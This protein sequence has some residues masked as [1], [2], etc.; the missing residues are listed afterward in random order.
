MKFGGSSLANAERVD[1]V[2]SLIKSQ[3]EQGYRPTVVCSAMGKTTNNLLNA[4]HFA[5]EGS[6]YIDS[7]RTLHLSTAQELGMGDEV[8]AALEELLDELKNLLNGVS[9]L[10]E[11]TPRTLDYLVSFGERLS[12]RIVAARLNQLGVP[13]QHFESWSL[14]LRTNSD[15]GK[16]EI[17]PESY[18][19]I[20]EAMKKLDDSMVAVVTGFIGH[21]SEGRITTLGRGG[22][23]LTASTI[24]A[25]VPVDEIQVWKD[26]NGIMT[27]NPKVVSN[28][29][30]VPFVSFEEASELAYFGAEILHPISMVPAM[31]YNIQVRVK[32][33]YNPDHPGTVILADK[34]YTQLVT[35]ITSKRNV[36]LLDIV[37]T[38]MLGQYGFL[39]RVFSIFEEQKV[40]V[41]CVATSEVSISLTL[42]TKKQDDHAEDRLVK[43]L[44]EIAAV[45][46]HRDRAIIS[47]IANVARSSEVLS[48]VFNALK[49]AGIQVEM[50]SQGASKVNI[51]LIV[52]DEDAERCTQILHDRFFGESSAVGGV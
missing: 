21:D 10:R 27:A 19:A 13:A 51:S 45:T 44:S 3:I 41:D 1:Y 30:P 7:L 38:W 26:V 22:S 5:L 11:L 46:V 31:R 28:A 6:V 8:L 50:L 12:V 2:A 43:A 52:K 9:C 14:G 48:I 42:D 32:N 35:A 18:S 24:G 37:S 23:D 20:K 29:V 4:G 49:E 17:L 36:E 39:S 25:A 16:A 47:L 40:S 33:S 34:D 15:F